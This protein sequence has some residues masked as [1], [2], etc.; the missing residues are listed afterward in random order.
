MGSVVKDKLVT[1]AI[2]ELTSLNFLM[3]I[4][5]HGSR[6]RKNDPREC[7]MLNYPGEMYVQGMK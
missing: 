5:I 7:T 3:V 4:N 2:K 6:I 1:I